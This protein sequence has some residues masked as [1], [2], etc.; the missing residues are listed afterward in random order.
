MTQELIVIKSV[1]ILTSPSQVWLAL[2]EPDKI[3][4]WMDGAHVE[5]KWEIGSN[6]TFAGTTP[7][8]NKPYRDHGTVRVVEH[9]KLLQYSRWSEMSRR[10]DLP[11]NRTIITF[12]LGPLDE[13]TSLAVRHEHFNSEV[14]YKHTNFFWGVA[15]HMMK[16]LLEH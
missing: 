14:E 4:Q 13:K 3:A 9:E 1:V 6:I 7:N 5:S 11:Q 15:L 10:P 8:F 2:T 12:T 16:N